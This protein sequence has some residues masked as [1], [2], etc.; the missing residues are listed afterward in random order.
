LRSAA[1]AAARRGDWLSAC[2]SY[3]ALVRKGR[4]TAGDRIQLAHVFKEQ[5]NKEAALRA[6]EAAARHYPLHLDAQRQLGLYLRR[7]NKSSEAAD[8]FARGLA[9]DPQAFDLK[10]EFEDMGLGDEAALDRHFLTGILAGSDHRPSQ[11]LNPVTALL[12]EWSLHKARSSAR[13]GDWPAAERYYRN[14]LKHVPDRADARVQLG[15]ALLEQGSA[16]E[17]LACY[18]CALVSAPRSPDVYLHVGHALKAL[19]RPD[20]AFDAYLVAWRLQ[21]GSAATLTELVGL[22]PDIDIGS[23]FLH[24]DDMGRMEAPSSQDHVSID[25]RH[26]LAA[27]SWLNSGQKATFKLLAGSLAPKD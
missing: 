20:S 8:A 16:A 17:A 27:P 23:L 1:R 6:Y 25:G 4:A 9:I 2:R 12:A 26:P 14:L 13:A 19:G 15:H 21:P 11:I 3:E 10:A 18:R 7:L 24:Q 5:D 22:R